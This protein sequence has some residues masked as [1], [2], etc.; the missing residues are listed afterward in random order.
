MSE[1][2]G[3]GPRSAIPNNRDQ[4]PLS[5]P[6]KTVEREPVTKVISGTAVARKPAWY[7]RVGKSFIA[8]DAD[9][10]GDFVVFDILIPAVKNA[11]FDIVKGGAERALF[12]SSSAGR[13]SSRIGERRG[14]QVSIRERY[15]A[16]DRPESRRDHAPQRA[17]A[18]EYRE[19][20]LLSRQEA[21][22]VL[23]NMHKRLERYPTVTV[24]D[25]YDFVGIPSDYTAHGYGWSNLDNANIRQLGR[26]WVLDLPDPVPLRD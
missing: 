18:L 15:A 17:G 23:D 7:R 9:T 11:V 12:G 8:E 1:P 10:L 14:S 26:K 25:L 19:I 24:K 6:A 21:L 13:M 2:V 22:D 20:E 5:A 16:M 4:T 3:I